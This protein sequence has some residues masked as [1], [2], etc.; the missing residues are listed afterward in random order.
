MRI[1]ML[2]LVFCIG[3]AAHAVA[4]DLQF[5]HG[6]KRL[7]LPE[8][9]EQLCDYTAMTRIRNTTD[10]RP[11]RAV[12]GAIAEPRVNKDTIVATGAAFRS[13]KEWYALSYTCTAN[14]EHLKV[15]SFKFEV[16]NAIPEKNWAA[17]G[18]WE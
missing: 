6:L 14:S 4:D 3:M 7:A 1:L 13:R 11:D 18:L 16:G 2:V 15:L 8:R 5:E 17:Y 12:A 10:F 9:L